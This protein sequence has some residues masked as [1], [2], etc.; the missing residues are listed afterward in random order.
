MF[1]YDCQVRYSEVDQKR[2]LTVPAIVNYLQDVCVMHSEHV[3]GGLDYVEGTGRIWMLGAWRIELLEDIYF[4]DEIRLSTWPYGFKSFYGYRNLTIE[5]EGRTCVRADSCWMLYSIEAG[6]PVRAEERDTRFYPCAP[7][8][9][10]EPF[11]Q[12]LSL[13]EGVA[14]TER[15]IVIPKRFIDTNGHVNNG[16]YVQMALDT[17]GITDGFRT[18]EVVY[19]KAAK[20]GDLVTCSARESQEGWLVDVTGEKG[21]LLSQIKLTR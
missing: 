19:R 1:S 21:E 8:L 10:M 5:K 2:R 17:L 18:V 12:K 13:E 7:R 4:K 15:Q 16:R 20:E 14:L 11:R 3:G 6:R 9:E